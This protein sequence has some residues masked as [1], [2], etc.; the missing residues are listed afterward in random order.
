MKQWASEDLE[1]IGTS[2]EIQLSSL[3][4][5]GTLRRPVTIWVV[6]LGN[7]LYV[8]A[9][10]GRKGTWFRGTQV[11]HEGHIRAGRLE[12]DV[13]FMDA[14]PALNEQI[15]EAYRSKYRRYSMRIINTILTPQAR[16]STLRLLPR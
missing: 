2:E 11:R 10:N 14:D 7:G 3:R 15:D 8:R 4:Q 16:D 13:G 12:Q 5:D 6:R 9:V 1:K